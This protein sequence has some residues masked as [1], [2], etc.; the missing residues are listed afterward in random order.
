M[1]ADL[2]P[3]LAIK[4]PVLELDTQLRDAA[5]DEAIIQ[6]DALDGVALACLPV[7]AVEVQ[8]SAPRDGAKFGVIVGE[9]LRDVTRAIP[10]TIA[11]RLVVGCHR[12]RLFKD[13]G[14][15]HLPKR[16]WIPLS[17]LPSGARSRRSRSS[18]QS[19]GPSR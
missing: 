10:G 13:C 15:K 5:I 16:W 9:R 8:G 19:C 17:R 18:R 11:R 14:S 12:Q 1:L 3:H 4:S 7:A 6:L 2:R